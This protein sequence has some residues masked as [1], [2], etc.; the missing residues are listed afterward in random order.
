M[1]SKSLCNGFRQC[2]AADYIERLMP[3]K[4][5]QGQD[6]VVAVLFRCYELLLCQ[7]SLISS[8]LYTSIR[9]QDVKT[10]YPS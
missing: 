1:G 7:P 5:P 9:Y 10:D 2:L 6:F 8:V 4:E 3:K